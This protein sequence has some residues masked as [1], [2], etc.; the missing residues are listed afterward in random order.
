MP[1]D[2]S[3]RLFDLSRLTMEFASGVNGTLWT[4]VK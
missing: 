3:C 4:P 1:G 2:F